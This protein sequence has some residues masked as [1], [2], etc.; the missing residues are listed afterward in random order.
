VLVGTPSAQALPTNYKD[1]SL[2]HSGFVG[3]QLV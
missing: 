3:E 1:G 2:N